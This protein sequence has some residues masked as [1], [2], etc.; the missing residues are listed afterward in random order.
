MFARS[1]LCVI[2]TAIT[3]PVHADPDPPWVDGVSEPQKAAARA[4]LDEGNAL[5]LAHRYA[6]ALEVYQRATAVWDHPAIRFNI[7]R[8][9]IQLDRPV[10]ASE[11]LELT[12]AYGAA[13]LQQVVY[14]EAQAYHKLLAGRIGELV[15]R[16]TEPGIALTLD[17]KPLATCPADERRRVAPGSHQVVGARRGFLTRTADV[18]VLGGKR[19]V[20]TMSLVSL[21]QAATITHRWP[22]GV[23]WYVLGGG[24]AATALGGVVQLKAAA[25][26]NSYDRAIR[27]SCR[28]VGCTPGAIDGELRARAIRENQLAIGLFA[29]GATTVV[30]GGTMLYL[31]RARTIYPS[32]DSPRVDVTPTRGGAAL[33]VQGAF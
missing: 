6:E 26:M 29:V 22:V 12:L 31:N 1:V 33:V 9:L 5:F 20:V 15:V 21:E 11:N 4:L 16:C 18:M 27:T 24:F 30:I 7:V 32:I 3:A 23:P 25:D 14:D 28:V 2:A 13:P 8:C 17:G 10:E 19:E